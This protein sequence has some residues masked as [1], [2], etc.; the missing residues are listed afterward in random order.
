[1][2][3]EK[4]LVGASG[5]MTITSTNAKTGSWWCI[6]FLADTVF[7]L[8][9]DRTADANGDSNVT[10]ITYLAGTTIEGDFTAITLASG[11]VRAHNKD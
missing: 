2:I 1:M 11:Q 3:P 6:K 8:L 4:L 7:T 9:T 5:A 10:G